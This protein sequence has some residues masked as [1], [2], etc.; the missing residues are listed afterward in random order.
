MKGNATI[1]RDVAFKAWCRC[2]ASEFERSMNK[3][4]LL[5]LW[6]PPC[7]FL[8]N[9]IQQKTCQTPW[10]V[11][12]FPHFSFYSCMRNMYIFLLGAVLL[13]KCQPIFLLGAYFCN[14]S[15]FFP[16]HTTANT[17]PEV[18]LC[19]GR[20]GRYEWSSFCNPKLLPVVL[21]NRFSLSDFLQRSQGNST[22]SFFLCRWRKCSIRG[23][24]CQWMRS[25]YRI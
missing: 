5:F 23:C 8:P 9:S 12:G 17:I 13:L 4:L 25:Y 7:Y 1:N 16:A 14:F 6:F 19:P 2:N 11:F 20:W 15:F 22:I 18:S 21:E 3:W 10:M 24:N